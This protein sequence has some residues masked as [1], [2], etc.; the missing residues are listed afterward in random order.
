MI[1]T[2]V[3]LITKVYLV[4]EAK[5][6]DTNI[7]RVLFLLVQAREAGAEGVNQLWMSDTQ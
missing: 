3:V 6:R 2:S 1:M 4:P 5:P 7:Q